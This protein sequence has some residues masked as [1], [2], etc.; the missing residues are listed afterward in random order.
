MNDMTP[1]A[2]VKI[3]QLAKALAAAQAQMK[4]AAKDASNPHFKSKYADLEAVNE[5]ARVLAENGIAI[6]CVPDGWSENRIVIRAMLVHSSGE[7]MEGRLEMPVSQPNNPQAV[8][9][10]LTYARRYAVSALAN[11]ATSDDDG[12]EAAQG[13][14][15]EPKK[16]QPRAVPGTPSPEQQAAPESTDKGAAG[17][18]PAAVKFTDALVAAMGEPATLGGVFSILNEKHGVIDINDEGWVLEAGSKLIKLRDTAPDQFARV[19][20]AYEARKAL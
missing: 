15:A 14:T 17:P 7:S 4:P 10:A 3:G 12:N 1:I 2:P 11:I 13:S 18:S 8:G 5:A 19:Q 16:A 20:A 6:M 9:S